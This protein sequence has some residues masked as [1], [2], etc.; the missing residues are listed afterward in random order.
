[1]KTLESLIPGKTE[2]EDLKKSFEEAIS[3][4]KN[5]EKV[6]FKKMIKQYKAS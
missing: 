1:L 2:L 3:A 6:L 4:A 5:D